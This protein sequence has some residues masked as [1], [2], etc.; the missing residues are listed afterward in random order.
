MQH[1]HANMTKY[2]EQI[3]IH[4]TKKMA[5]ELRRDAALHQRSLSQWVRMLIDETLNQRKA[6]RNP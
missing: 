6:A 5:R 3:L 2:P 4:V 1:T